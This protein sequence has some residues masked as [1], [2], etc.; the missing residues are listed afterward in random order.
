MEKMPHKRKQAVDFYFFISFY[1]LRIGVEKVWG[2]KDRGRGSGTGIRIKV[3][4]L[5]IIHEHGFKT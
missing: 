5:P 1:F 2:R 4:Q 3:F